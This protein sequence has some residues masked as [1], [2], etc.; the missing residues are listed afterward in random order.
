M[1]LCREASS[2]ASAPDDPEHTRARER[3]RATVKIRAI[4]W[5]AVD[6]YL[7][8]VRLPFDA[9]IRKFPDGGTGVRR[10]AQAA[11]DGA[12]AGVRAT[13][14][15]VLGDPPSVGDATGQARHDDREDR[16]DGLGHASTEPRARRL[17]EQQERARGQRGRT[18]H[19]A[20]PAAQRAAPAGQRAAPAG[21]QAAPAERSTAAAEAPAAPPAPQSAPTSR[22]RAAALTG[23]ATTAARTAGSATRQRAS[24][25][26]RAEPPAPPASADKP[27]SE[28]SQEEIAARAYEL[29]QRGVPG[30][31]HAHWE[32]AK[33][34]LTSGSG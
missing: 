30:D 12:D 4:H 31:A 19:K 5:A 14:A 8:L 28:P 16:H 27:S 32:A 10:A 24:D 25:I 3:E 1:V 6:T 26:A 15:M 22:A 7:K 33:R 11:V 18:R 17:K 9:A 29:Y 13:V 20:A 2:R 23:T 21:Q 34:E